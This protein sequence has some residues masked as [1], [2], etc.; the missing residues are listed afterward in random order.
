MTAGIDPLMGRK[1]VLSHAA[2]ER[3]DLDVVEI[4]IDLDEPVQLPTGLRVDVAVELG[5][6]T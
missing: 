4:L 1:R 5:G 6:P 2:T 3:R